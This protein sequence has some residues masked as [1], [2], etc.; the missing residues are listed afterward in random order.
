MGLLFGPKRSLLGG[1]EAPVFKFD[2]SLVTFTPGMDK[3]TSPGPF[4]TAPIVQGLWAAETINADIVRVGNVEIGDHLAGL[5]YGY[6]DPYQGSVV[7][8][9]TPEWDGDDGLRHDLYSN[10]NLFVFKH[11]NNGLYFQFY[12]GGSYT[13]YYT[14]I[15]TWVAGNTYFVVCR[16]DCNNTLDGTNHICIS[17]NDSHAFS[18]LAT[19]EP[20]TI[21]EFSHYVGSTWDNRR[22]GNAIIEGLTVYRR[23]LYD[24]TYGVAANW[25]DSGPIDEIAAIYAAGA[26]KDPC[27]VTGSWGVVFC[28]PTNSTAEALTTGTGEA[29]S[30][31]H[32]SGILEHQW[33]EDGGYLGRPWA[34][35]FDYS[36]GT[37]IN[38]GSG[39]TLD[40]IP[41]G[42][43]MT[44]EAWVRFTESYGTYSPVIINKHQFSAGQGWMLRYSENGTIQFTLRLATTL[45]AAEKSGNVLDDQKWHHIVGC[46]VDATKTAYLAVDGVWVDSDVGAGAYQSDAALDLKIGVR[47]DDNSH[48]WD[49]AIGWCAISSND[50]YG[51]V[52]GTDFIPPRQPPATDGNHVEMWH[53]DEG[54]GATANAE[55]TTP[56][57]D[58]TISNGTWEEQWDQE[59]SP[60]IPQSLEFF[61]QNDGIN[62]GSGANID[63][64]PSGD[65]TIEFWA[66]F[67]SGSTTYDILTK[68]D[69]SIT[70]GWRI[71]K[72]A[73]QI[74]FAILHDSNWF[75]KTPAFTAD[76]KW[77]HIALDWD[78]GTLTGRIFYDGIYQSSD[79]AVG[80]YLVDAA[81]DCIVNGRNAIGTADGSFTIGWI[82]LSNNRRYSGGN[83][84]PPSRLNPPANDANAQLLINMDDGAGTTATDTSGNG[85]NGTITFGASTIWHN[86]PD[87]EI[88]SPGERIFNW[89][90]TIGNDAV[91]EGIVETLSGLSAGQNYVVR[92]VANVESASRG[93]PKI[94]IY[95]ETNGAQIT[96]LEGPSF[97]GAHDGLA[98]SA[99]LTDTTARFPQMLVGWTIYNITDGSSATITA[100]SGDMQTITGALSGGT[101]DDWD[102]SDEYRI[103][104]PGGPSKYD[105]YPWIETFCFEL[106]T[107]ARNGVASDCTSI[108]VKLVNG[109]NNGVIKWH[110]IELLENLVDNPSLETGAGDPWIPDGW[111]NLNLDAG[112]TEQ[113]VIT[114]HSGSGSL[115]WNVGAA[116]GEGL[117]KPNI[118]GGS[119]YIMQGGWFQA[120]GAMAIRYERS[121]SSI[122]GHDGSTTYA[123]QIFSS[124]WLHS[125]VV[126][127]RTGANSGPQ[128]ASRTGASGDRFTDDMYAFGLDDV[129]LTVTP[130]SE[131]KSAESGGLRVDGRDACSQPIPA[132]I[133]SDISGHIKWIHRP[134]HEDADAL[135]YGSVGPTF[136]QFR[137]DGSNY[138][139][140]YWN[141]GSQVQMRFVLG[142]VTTNVNWNTGG[143]FT[144]DADHILEVKYDDT[145]CLFI[146]DGVTRIT[147]TPGGGINWGANIPNVAYW[148]I[149]SPIRY[150]IDAIFR[151]P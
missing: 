112:D 34:V 141:A 16:W 108:S 80:A 49:G 129:S 71:Y 45:A 86:T 22:S 15:S 25:D 17:I 93:R 47:S 68:T 7:F 91:D 73:T 139:W 23:P 126:W 121:N 63:N 104:P 128:L 109:V 118:Y 123:Q 89:G 97:T 62:F 66:K 64:L 1:V 37:N 122:I 149:Q 48:Y 56:G 105:D 10:N 51:A 85:Y 59:T 28:L 99:T 43:T 111:T 67:P 57:N 33:L 24:G 120:D 114:V 119:N 60:I 134:R 90:Y 35:A 78:V 95:D 14:D 65:C 84:T 21:S 79:S 8:W 137:F 2:S 54:T 146:V 100:I 125:S 83:F 30:H 135:D 124:V 19:I 72:T 70:L 87:M 20:L 3:R 113:D 106:P 82:R 6:G 142:G 74:G 41:S 98:N 102:I 96:A 75:L 5:F 115:E 140:I 53:L 136:A 39:A 127:I 103:V 29:W 138:I 61:Y 31:P 101:D 88:D 144:V 116:D 81:Q 9:V 32:S 151:A 69:N 133:L 46:Y 42:A 110:Q 131:A 143:Y 147:V 92:A 18:L 130:A 12:D 40:D 145:E 150:Q 117:Y 36:S 132:G 77:H 4:A 50:R 38:C 27:L 58:G 94:I 44:V 13:G 76:D 107:I 11:A 148:G 52:A 55:V 26:G